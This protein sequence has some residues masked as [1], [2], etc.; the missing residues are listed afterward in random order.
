MR[1]D[2]KEKRITRRE[3]SREEEIPKKRKFTRRGFVRKGK[4]NE[5]KV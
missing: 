3:N 1:R 2:Y 5:E 4:I